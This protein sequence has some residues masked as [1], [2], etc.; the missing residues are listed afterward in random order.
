LTEKLAILQGDVALTAEEEAERSVRSQELARIEE[1]IAK[2]SP[3]LKSLQLKVTRI[4]RE[5]MSVGGMGVT[6]A[7]AKIDSLSHQIESLSSALAGKTIEEETLKKTLSKLSTSLDKANNEIAKL[8]ERIKQ[9]ETEEA[10]MVT[11]IRTIEEAMA[12]TKS[13][14][15]ELE[16]TLL[17]KQSEYKRVKEEIA[18]IKSVEVDLTLELERVNAE[19]KELSK[20]KTHWEGELAAIRELHK[21]EQMEMNDTVNEIHKSFALPKVSQPLSPPSPQSSFVTISSLTQDG[22]AMEIDEDVPSNTVDELPIFPEE[23]L[24]FMKSEEIKREIN[25]LETERNK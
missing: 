3:E 15:S 25:L 16:S 8:S 12:S 13:H 20:T 7:T 22:D 14:L 24:Q 10:D 6:K 5:I 4:S 11:D 19:A 23:D 21:A 2:A 9:L 17:T 18:S 1:N